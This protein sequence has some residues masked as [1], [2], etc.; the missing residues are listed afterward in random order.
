[1][2]ALVTG[3]SGGLGTAV[4]RAL[5]DAGSAVAIGFHTRRDVAEA[6]ACELTARAG[7]AQAIGLEVAD[8][9]RMGAAIE[10]VVRSF[11]GLD[12]LVNAAA[13]NVDHM[14]S[15]SDP[16]EVARMHAVNVAGGMNAIRAALPHLMASGRGR[17][18][19]FSSVLATRAMPGVSAYAGTKG[20][21]ESITRALAAELGPKNITVNAIAPG[22]IDAGLGR[23]PV[24]AA[25]AALRS[26]VPLRRAGRAEEVAAVVA[27]LVSEAAS[28]VNGAVLPVDGGLLAGS[29]MFATPTLTVMQGADTP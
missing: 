16:A 29:R 18:I 17:I 14:L 15:E 22:Y 3:G 7:R 21:I 8:A 9:E 10:E 24:E 1:M 6:L 11:G 5:A 27:F 4:C 12:V 23:K 19:N 20:A 2:I 28:Y 25:G 13:Y 26:L